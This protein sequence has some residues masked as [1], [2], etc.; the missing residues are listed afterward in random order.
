MPP[1]PPDREK[2]PARL[3]RLTIE[4]SP[5]RLGLSLIQ[6]ST[7]PAP[8]NRLCLP[9]G[10]TVETFPALSEKESALIDRLI[11]ECIQY[12]DDGEDHLSEIV[13][14]IGS[15][16]LQAFLERARARMSQPHDT[17]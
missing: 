4:G 2:K 6:A 8:A 7:L 11:D 3:R 13:D 12:E 10:G 5:R 1:T 16:L 17:R 9:G 14:R 15:K